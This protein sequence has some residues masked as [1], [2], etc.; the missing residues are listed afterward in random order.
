MTFKII[1][2]LIRFYNLI[3]EIIS[4][5]EATRFLVIELKY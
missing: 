5:Y 3:K 4:L 1:Y 2:S